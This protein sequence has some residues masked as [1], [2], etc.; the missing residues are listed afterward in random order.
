[1]FHDGEKAEA[2]AGEGIGFVY[3]L[4]FH[5]SRSR[6]HASSFLFF[7]YI[8]LRGQSRQAWT[9]QMS[10]GWDL[11]KGSPMG[12][13]GGIRKG[14]CPTYF[15]APSLFP[16]VANYSFLLKTQYQS[17]KAPSQQMPESQSI[18]QTGW[19]PSLWG[20]SDSR[21]VVVHSLCTKPHT[22]QCKSQA[23]LEA[24][25]HRL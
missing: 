3:S 12:W 2:E 14:R 17:A 15:S 13:L 1:M 20:Y 21:E 11:A 23:E 18:L 4:T 6:K 8:P 19:S 25:N 16:P 5:P 9:M 10:C 24:F 22:R 7:G